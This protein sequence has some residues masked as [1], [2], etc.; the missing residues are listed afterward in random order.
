MENAAY[1]GLTVTATFCEE[2]IYRGYLQRQFTAWT[3]SLS[4]G[5]VCQG[6]VF[7]ASHAYLGR[8]MVL[9][10]VVYGCL[11]GLLA[12]GARVCVPA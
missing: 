11:F 6:I 10:V 7:G 12:A 1:L 8:A 2:L 4:I 3:G 5:V 9:V